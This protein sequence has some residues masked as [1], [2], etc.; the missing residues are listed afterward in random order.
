MSGLPVVAVLMCIEDHSQLVRTIDGFI[1]QL[2][3]LL[4]DR[5]A[6]SMAVLCL[7][8]VA[9][10]F[11]RRMAARSDAGGWPKSDG[12][13]AK[14]VTVHA[15]LLPTGQANVH[16]A[17]HC[18]PCPLVLHLVL[19]CTAARMAKWL[20]RGVSP[21]VQAMVRGNLP[22]PEQQELVRQLC[23]SVAPHLP[24]YAI[25]GMVL[26]LLQVDLQAGETPS[27]SADAMEDS[28]LA[29]C[30][31]GVVLGSADQMPPH[32]CPMPP[33]TCL[34]NSRL[35]AS[36]WPTQAPTGRRPWRV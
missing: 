3:K 29:C 32:P 33:C 7:C 11:I 24:E 27:M 15:P 18:C 1:D 2:Q 30:A 12:W 23:A 4:R 35:P 25:T 17:L 36:A 16:L 28:L 9:A 20:S 13:Q 8:R 5:R 31:W 10:C 34:L 19:R 6:A 22:A 21:V 26:E 14:A